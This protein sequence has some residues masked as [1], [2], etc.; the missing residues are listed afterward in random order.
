[1]VA[2]ACLIRKA[3]IN[4]VQQIYDLILHLAEYEKAPHEVTNS[5][6]KI[7]E[8]GFGPNPLFNAWVAELNGQIV[9]LALC[10]VRYSTWKG[11]LLY[12]EDIVVHENYRRMGIGKKLLNACLLYCSEKRFPRLVFQVLDWNQ[13]AI[14]FYKQYRAGFDPQWVNVVIEANVQ[15][16]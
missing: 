5:P 14:E 6:E 16:G 10:Y 7:A 3:S 9:G 15:N 2:D 11:P 13:P 8:D 1:M 4:D 12:L